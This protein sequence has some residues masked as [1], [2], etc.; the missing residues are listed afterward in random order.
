MARRLVAAYNACAGLRTAA[1]ERGE[2]EKALLFAD[3]SNG[4]EGEQSFR[5]AEFGDWDD[6]GTPD[7]RCDECSGCARWY[8][9]KALQALKGGTP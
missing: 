6:G 4:I 8:T 1:L 2:L 5:C 9:D 7:K 3:A